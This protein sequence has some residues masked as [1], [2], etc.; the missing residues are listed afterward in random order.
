VD[1][2]MPDT[3]SKNKFL[4]QTQR[5]E[6]IKIYNMFVDGSD[7]TD[8]KDDMSE[9]L[10]YLYNWS[11]RGMTTTSQYKE[12]SDKILNTLKTVLPEMKTSP[13]VKESCKKN[14][15][16]I[17]EQVNSILESEEKLIVPENYIQVEKC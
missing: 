2:R 4:L 5:E 3:K 1:D 16:E 9:L 13:I 12:I 14:I 10:E 8:E 6:I 11:E 7:Y 15:D 17:L